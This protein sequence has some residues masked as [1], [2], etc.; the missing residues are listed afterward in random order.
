LALASRIYA[1]LSLP[2]PAWLPPNASAGAI[3]TSGSNTSVPN[4]QWSTLLGELL[5]AYEA[6]RSGK[7]P[8][9]NRVSWRNDSALSDGSDVGL[10]LTGGYYDA[11]D[12]IKVGF[13][14]SFTLSS[15]CWGAIDFGKGYDLTNQT[16]YLDS[17]LRWG[18]DWLIKT[19]PS[20]DTLY[21]AVGNTDIDDD[22]WGGDQDIPGPRPSYQI[23]DTSPGT[24]A[25]AGISAAFAACSYLY[26]G[27]S[28]SPV[29]I[30][31]SNVNS[32]APASLQNTT[33]AATL[34]SHATELYSFA[35]NASGGMA[36]YQDSVPEVAESYPSGGYGDELVYAG[37]WLSLAVNASQSANTNSSNST[38]NISSLSPQQYYSLA[39]SY[40]GQFKLSGQNPVFNWDDKTAGTYILFAQM[41]SLGYEGASNFS[42]WQNEAERYLDAVIDPASSGGDAYLTKGG[43]L[44]YP[45]DSNDATLNPS[46]N[47]AMLLTRYVAAGL[48]SSNDKAQNYLSFAQSQL[49]YTLGKNPMFVPYVVGLHPNSPINPQSAMSSGGD[50]INQVDTSPPLS[51][52]NTYVLYGGVVGGPDQYDRFFDIRSDWVETEV[53]MDYMAPLLTLTAMHIITD[54]SDPY[55]TQ[56]QVG[57]YNT[58]K[59]KGQPCDDAISAGC[60]RHHLSTGGEIALG[61]VLGVTG[62]VVLGLLGMWLRAIRRRRGSMKS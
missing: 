6:Q 4:E 16:A 42:Q 39:E 41:A 33:Y 13:P 15:I 46:L 28:L 17:M 22:Y 1:Q 51:Q 27:G 57:A 12:Y 9:T 59:P 36:L 11:G 14:L 60:A 19:H 62:F 3:S 52:G 35:V 48:S 32:T 53:G 38:A 47:A 61:V 21:V 7:L 44:F 30:G 29:S 25:A 26:Y 34:L 40:Y 18:L 5:Y 50:D 37:L 20:N 58:V 8:D 10:D 56:V 43:L 23:N 24:D 54:N 31:K 2:S 45:G 55:Y 49:D